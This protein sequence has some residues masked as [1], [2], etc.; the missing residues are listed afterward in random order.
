M[1]SWTEKP[2]LQPK[3][4]LGKLAR[5]KGL[6]KENETVLALGQ[7]LGRGVHLANG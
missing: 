2:S 1:L 3:G 4:R 7:E 5:F 6:S